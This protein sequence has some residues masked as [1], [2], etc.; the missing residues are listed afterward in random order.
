MV[1]GLILASPWV[2]Y[3]IWGFVAPGLYP[4]EKRLVYRSVPLFVALFL[5][6]VLFGWTVVLPGSIDFMIRFNQDAGLQHQIA[7]SSWATFAVVFPA[8]FGV[9]F[10]LPLAM[11]VLSKIGLATGAGLRKYRKVAI[12]LAAIVSAVLTPSPYPMDMILM[13]V[14]LVLL[15][16]A[17]IVCVWLTDRRRS[18]SASERGQEPESS[19]DL[20]ASFL[21]PFLTG[22]LYGRGMVGRT[23]SRI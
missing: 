12:V 21:V 14:P 8:A 6:G 5:A 22:R 11:I 19:N 23:N 13:L 4:N 7:V 18:R 10:E 9:A 17:G 16:E 20:M 15:Y 3:Q 1:G 2:V